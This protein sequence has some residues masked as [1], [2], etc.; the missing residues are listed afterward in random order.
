LPRWPNRSAEKHNLKD[1]TLIYKWVEGS[2]I[3]DYARSAQSWN[4]FTGKEDFINDFRNLVESTGSSNEE[5][6]AEVE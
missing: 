1:P 5:R 2:D 6:A 4:D 3:K